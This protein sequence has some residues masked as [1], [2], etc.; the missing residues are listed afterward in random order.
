MKRFIYIKSFILIAMF[1]FSSCNKKILDYSDPNSINT[2]SY[3]NTP[4]QIQQASIAIYSG[5]FYNSMFGWRW[6]EMFDALANEI[7]PQPGA[8]GNES[9]IIQFRLYQFNAS[10]NVI[11]GYWD[12]LY[13]MILRANL[14]I[15]KGNL[16]IKNHGANDEVSKAVGDAYFLRGW[17]YT[18]LAFYW[19]KVPLRTVFDQ[20]GNEDEPR[21]ANASDVWAVAESDLKNAELLLPATWDAPNLG[22]ATSGAASGFLGKLYLYNNKY[23]SADAEFVKMNGKYSLLPASQW[24]DNFGETNKNNQESVFEIQ[25]DWIAGSGAGQAAFGEPEGTSGPPGRENI[26]AQLYGWNDWNNWNFQAR[27]VTDFIYTDESGNPYTDPRAP[28]TFYGGIGDSVWCDQ[29]TTNGPIVYDFATL[30]YYYK[31]NLNKEYKLNEGGLH[32]SNNIRLMRYADVLLMRAECAL[33]G[34]SADVTKAIGFINQ[35]RTRVGA[36]PYNNTYTADQAFVLLQRERQLEFMG[37]QSRFNDLK[38]WNILEQFVNPELQA[39]GAS[40]PFQ[41]KYYLFPIPQTEIDTNLKLG[42]VA[43]N[44]N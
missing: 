31:K 44:W 40:G 36:F 43:N 22:R 33:K 5:F 19:G 25:C 16:Y 18:Q 14:T 29:C 9:N 21:A 28:L 6:E 30:G 1:F 4:D 32:S 2:D 39:I 26:H 3:F 23:D 17:A 10:N 8:L 11:S 35:V 7:N 24:E 42:T 37:E 38:R 13:R 12:L 41:S 15:D 27:R 20:T 34:A